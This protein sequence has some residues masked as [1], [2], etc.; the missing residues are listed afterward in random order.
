MMDLNKILAK[1]VVLKCFQPVK[2]KISAVQ[3][4][5][6]Y[7]Q[8]K[9]LLLKNFHLNDASNLLD[10]KDPVVVAEGL[11]LLAPQLEPDCPH[12]LQVLATANQSQ[13]SSQRWQPIEIKLTQSSSQLVAIVILKL[14]FHQ[15]LC[16]LLIL[17]I[18]LVH[19]YQ[20][21]LIN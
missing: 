4:Q 21:Y 9:G 10:H 11:P 7:K 8:Y 20:L 19:L 13:N 1:T 6:M 18:L 17:H 15:N 12:P 3:E 16:S 5:K 14:L 2:S